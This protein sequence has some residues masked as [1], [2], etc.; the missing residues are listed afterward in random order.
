M[1]GM[2]RNLLDNLMFK[3]F[4]SHAK[5]TYLRPDAI[6][7]I[8]EKLRLFSEPPENSLGLFRVLLIFLYTIKELA[9]G[10][11][12]RIRENL[13][14][15]APEILQ[16][17]V[18]IYS[19]KVARWQGFLA[20]GV[21]DE[22]FRDAAE[23]SLLA[24]R[25]LRRLII[26]TYNHPNRDAVVQQFWSQI[27]LQLD[28]LLSF[29]LR[30]S[31][32]ASLNGRGLIEKHLVQI[33]KFHLEMVKTHPAGFALLSNSVDLARAYW[34]LV[35]RFSQTFGSQTP[36]PTAKIRNDGDADEE[37]P[38]I[39]EA[40]SL[41]GL[42]LLRGCLKM[43][44][45]PAQTFKYQH[46]EDKDEK[47][48]AMELIRN[49]L[50]TENFVREMMET[51]VTQF[52]VFR[53]RDLRDWAEEPEEWERREEGEGDVWEFSIR[54]CSEK[55]FLDLVINFN[56]LLVEPLLRVFA[57][58][59]GKSWP[60]IFARS[61]LRCVVVANTNVLLKDSVYAAIGIAAPVLEEKL[62]FSTFLESTLV[63]EVQIQQAGY[64]ILRRRIAIVLGQWLPVKEGLNRPL[65]YQIFQHL[66]DKG[67]ALNDQ[68]VRVTAGRQLKNVIDPFEFLAEP[69]MP[70]TP[71]ILGRLMQL[72][73]EV[74]LSETK[75]ALLNTISIIVGKMEHHVWARFITPTT[76]G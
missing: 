71:V 46:P 31:L 40:L 47:K 30:G 61:G 1:I 60:I 75:M 17:L 37:E 64:N 39:L 23:R 43:V 15:A 65:V 57:N 7:T 66:L 16:V 67:D 6:S 41:K 20:D 58:V 9:T 56:N 12:R 34:R 19:N 35:F 76:P 28:G 38:A 51:I 11:L 48:R 4:E 52:F 26:A 42:L 8:V 3:N 73:E 13:Q 54:S 33:A 44:F 45:S 14:A 62:D 59:A 50:L 29:I 49:T 5:L 72:V 55:L 27:S 18:S 32:S 69:F 22:R 10:Q 53:S 21:G 24:L 68:V 74:E 70:Y 63:P 36:T 2:I 25:I